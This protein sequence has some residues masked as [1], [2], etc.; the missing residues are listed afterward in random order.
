[1]RGEVNGIESLSGRAPGPNWKIPR[2]NP[3]ASGRNPAISRPSLQPRFSLSEVL[4]KI[5]QAL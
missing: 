5:I 1:M 2:K 3:E 4:G